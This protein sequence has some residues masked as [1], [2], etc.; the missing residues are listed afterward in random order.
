M[1]HD[2]ATSPLGRTLNRVLLQY[3][4]R[5]LREH[6][7]TLP[8]GDFRYLNSPLAG[9][10]ILDGSTRAKFARM[11]RSHFKRGRFYAEPI[12]AAYTGTPPPNGKRSYLTKQ[13]ASNVWKRSFL[14]Q[15]IRRSHT[16]LIS[17]SC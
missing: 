3:Q 17:I 10:E 9:L 14:L 13:P 5:A 1:Q 8:S 12:Y 11:V 15:L 4:G 6:A 16:V 7:E 2:N